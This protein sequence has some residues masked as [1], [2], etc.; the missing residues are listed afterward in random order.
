MSDLTF[1]QTARGGG[2][3]ATL[4][5][6]TDPRRASVLDDIDLEADTDHC[7]SR[8]C[9]MLSDLARADRR[10]EVDFHH[11]HRRR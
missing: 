6:V 8:V 5:Y 11:V 10:S 1:R 7:R 4:T 3:S 9:D 2:W